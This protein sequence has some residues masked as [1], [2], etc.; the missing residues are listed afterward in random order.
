M[1][2]LITFRK[3]LFILSFFIY[4]S[5]FKTEEDLIDLT[6]YSYPSPNESYYN[7]IPILSTNDFHGGIFP[8]KYADSKKSRFSYGGANYL[9]S[10][11]KILKEEWGDRLIWLDA[12]DQFT[13]T[14][15]CMLS[16]CLIMKDYYNKAGLDA[17]A[18][19]NHDFDY[20]I[21]Y[22]KKY[23][24]EMNFPLIVANVKEISTDKYIYE[25][26]ENVKAYK[27]FE[28]KMDES[29][30]KKIIKIGVIGLATE[31]TLIMTA[32]DMSSLA[33][34]DYVEETKKWNDYLREK[35]N[36]NAVIALTH[37]GPL[38]IEDGPEK[39]T[40]KMRDSST[41]QKSCDQTQEANIYMEKLKVEKIKI[42]AII[43]GHVH[44]I[45]HHWIADIPVV[46]SSGSDYFNI[47]YLPFTYNSKTER[48]E[49]QNKKIQIEGPVPVCDK[50][51]PNSKNCEYKYEDSSFMKNFKFHGKEITLDKEM[52]YT[53][54]YWEKIIKD[55]VENNLVET[56]DEMYKIT[57][58]ESLLTNFINDAGR[59]ITDS[60]ICFYN[61]GG[62]RTDWH[63]GPINEIDV[64]RMLPFNNTWVRFEMTGEEIF[65][66]F[67]IMDQNVIYP[68]SGVSLYFNKKNSKLFLK[69]IL[70]YDGFEE[71][72]LNP[73]QTYKVCTN[74][75][76]AN[77]GEDMKD[78]RS[79]YKEL[80]NKKDFGNIR[81]LMKNFMAKFKGN[82]REDKFVDKRNP[83]YIFDNE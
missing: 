1:E 5:S 38:C 51:W 55:K 42:D 44:N 40:L 43:A 74:D 46:E 78:V 23:I 7:Y 32:T 80:R 41:N 62:I 65:H 54:Q 59:I 37:F 83:K 81:D 53:L 77:G 18:L 26:W 6:D 12:G 56:E 64:F 82:I 24:K 50:L 45:V 57:N 2:S 15:E 31:L 61:N 28:I 47:I 76:L 73:K 66:M 11:K 14:M 69:N 30:P 29:D 52:T 63:R 27:I 60:D 33:F 75:F 19:G 21:D 70:I 67:Y 17:I 9:Y 3:I 71:R 48:Y 10:Y 16:D 72:P 20:D 4:S 35:E 13:G 8:S 68:S 49:I 79:W 39:Y 25:T 58:E 34:T 22:L 36:V